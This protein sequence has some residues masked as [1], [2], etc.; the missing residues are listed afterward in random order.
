MG[1]RDQSSSTEDIY[2][3]QRTHETPSSDEGFLS[4]ISVSLSQIFQPVYNNL[5]AGRGNF[6]SR[7]EIKLAQARFNTAV[8]IWVSQAIAVG[9]ILGMAVGVL[10]GVLL[11]LVIPFKDIVSGISLPAFLSGVAPTLD[12]GLWL[13]LLGLVGWGVAN[14][15]F[16]A[17]WA[18]LFGAVGV[19]CGV[20][21]AIYRPGFTIR[22][23]K[24]S[25]DTVMPEVVGFMHSLSIGG[26]DTLDIFRAVADSQDTYG[27]AAVEFRELVHKIDNLNKDYQT[28]IRETAS[29]SPN[30]KLSQFFVDMLSIINS[31]GDLENFLESK[32]NEVMEERKKSHEQTLDALEFFGE[33]YITLTVFPLLMLVIL[34]MMALF[35]DAPAEL[36]WVTVYLLIPVL[37]LGYLI[38]VS[39]VTPDPVGTG[40]LDPPTERTAAQHETSSLLNLGLVSDHARNSASP[41]FDQIWALEFQYK[42]SKLFRERKQTLVESPLYTLVFS[43]PLTLVTLS[44][45]VVQGVAKLSFGAFV[46]SGLVQSFVWFGLPFVLTVTPIAVFYEIRERR[47]GSITETLTANLRKMANTNANG[48][49]LLDSIKLAGR[50]NPSLLGQELTSIYKQ[51][52]FGTTLSGALVEF[53]NR[54]QIPRL[55]RTVKLINKS[56]E[57]SSHIPEVL[58]TAANLSQIEDDLH[59]NKQTRTRMQVAIVGLGFLVF[60]GVLIM[61]D[62]YFLDT[63]AGLASES[64]SSQA[65]F[66]DFGGISQ[67]L[68]SMFY[69]HTTLI[70]GLFGGL[71]AGYMREDTVVAGLKYSIA[72]VVIAFVA[73]GG[74]AVLI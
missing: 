28:A 5:F 47:R 53:N 56:Q 34:V 21:Y 68:L 67:G 11:W 65:D 44:L 3:F 51:V 36:L 64:E 70:Q 48:R 7:L 30:E 55:A 73:W 50:D 16:I 22:Q 33:V 66:A 13:D 4:R 46:D 39:T 32:K 35:G 25:I 12:G 10:V 31:G 58:T 52:R 37:N 61:M 15:L 24:Q 20:A 27:E 74:A 9:M 26:T 8:E 38:S 19:L 69:I 23:R 18:A 42:L 71:V 72:F 43:I 63:I 14:G 59:D 60:L 54:Y 41:I 17:V 49:S 6:V 2:N 45:L 57:S 1:T 62:Q 29:S 40:R